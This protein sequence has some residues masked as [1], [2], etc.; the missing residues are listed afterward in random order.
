MSTGFLYLIGI[1]NCV[2]SHSKQSN[3]DGGTPQ[4]KIDDSFLVTVMQIKWAGWQA[5][6]AWK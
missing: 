5:Q 4:P 1:V 6:V 3:G 2:K